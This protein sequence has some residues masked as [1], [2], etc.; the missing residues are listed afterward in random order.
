MSVPQSGASPRLLT[1]TAKQARGSL[2]APYSYF[3]PGKT[4]NVGFGFLFVFFIKN[5]FETLENHSKTFL[6]ECQSIKTQLKA[7]ASPGLV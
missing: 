7:G 3:L 6:G 1:I 4:R 5:Y 2:G